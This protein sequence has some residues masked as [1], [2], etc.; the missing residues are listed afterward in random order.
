MTEP[1]S[2]PKN[3]RRFG[4]VAIS[5]ALV[6]IAG[7]A[8]VFAHQGKSGHGGP[9]AE[10]AVEMHLEHVQT[11][12][13][14][15]GASDAQKAQIEAILKPALAEMKSAH[16]SHSAAF[17]QFH[18]ELSAPSL[19]RGRIE[20]LRAAQ[21]KSLDEASRR[22]VTAISDAAEVLTPEQRKALTEEIASHHRG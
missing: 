6:A 9:M 11:M 3:R 14:K 13:T 22:L 20:A 4:I 1:V 5:V 10:H 17:K 21:I 18:E 15:I 16:E 2:Q 8:L 19:D 7:T 12:L